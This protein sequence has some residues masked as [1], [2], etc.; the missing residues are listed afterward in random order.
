MTIHKLSASDFT[1]VHNQFIDNYMADANGEFVKIYLYLLRCSSLNA[2]LS[3][4]SI[5]DVFNCTERDVQRAL[6]YWER[7]QL[8]RLSFGPDGIL[9]DVAFI[10]GSIVESQRTERLS[11][12][13]QPTRIQEQMPESAPERMTISAERRQELSSSDEI[14]QLIFVIEQYMKK[15]LSATELDHILYFY[16]ELHFS[17]DLIEYLVEYCL[18]KGKRSISY[19]RTVAL[20]WY[21]KG[22]TTVDEAKSDTAFFHK[23]YYTILNAFGIR[24]R[25]PAQAEIDYMKRW[26][27]E[28]HYSTDVILEACRRTINR[29]HTPSFPYAD[30]ILNGWKE[31]G[32]RCFA[33]IT[34]LDKPP[35]P[36]AAPVQSAAPSSRT[37]GTGTRFNNFVQREYDFD[38]LEQQLLD[39]QR[40]KRHVHE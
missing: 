5:A 31:K 4:S 30:S 6:N 10:D 22:V 9:T 7:Q 17:A 11:S 40:R 13:A 27:N 35:V 29:I 1:L 28:L 16:D 36:A 39:S 37:Q 8:L 3:L 34:L 2:Q 38:E 19:I 23:D 14:Q 24:G 26:L 12:Y 32:V 21:K 33:D 25:G 15:M 20:E 18:S